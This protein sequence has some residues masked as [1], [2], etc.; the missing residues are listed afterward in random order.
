MARRA[1]TDDLLAKWNAKGYKTCPQCAKRFCVLHGRG[2]LPRFC[3][4]ACKQK[5]YRET[6]KGE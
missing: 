6:K 2:R 4:N 5:W 1:K 3:S